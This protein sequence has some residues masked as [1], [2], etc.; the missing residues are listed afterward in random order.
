MEPYLSQRFG[1]ASEPHARGREARLGL[2]QARRRLAELLGCEPGQLV[3]TSGGTEADNQAVFGLC[4]RPLGR[5]V[6][7]AI[8]HSAVRAPALE[9]ERQGFEVAFAPVDAQG[10][11][12]SAGSPTSSARATG[13]LR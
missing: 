12:D 5:L 10:V 13:W 9:L 7:S 11:V 8:E 6:A 3:F 2:E 1:N 4:G